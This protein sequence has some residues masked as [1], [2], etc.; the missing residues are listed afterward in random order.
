MNTHAISFGLALVLAT[1]ASASAL[2]QGAA[3]VGNPNAA[4]DKIAMCV[5]CHGIADYKASFP[6]VYRVPKLG[7]QNAQYI[8]TALT[9][10]QKGERKHPTMD[11][12]AASLSP[13][14]MADIAAYYSQQK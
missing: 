14:D 1:L 8:V 6:M 5:G 2:A 3:P 7:G 9:E 13:Q 12:V 11:G 10:Y 4:H